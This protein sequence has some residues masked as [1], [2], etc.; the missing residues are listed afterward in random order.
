MQ[1]DHRL[2]I[3]E[4]FFVRVDDFLQDPFDFWYVIGIGDAE[5]KINATLPLSR[6]ILDDPGPDQ[7]VG[8]DN[9]LVVK[10]QEG[11]IYQAHLINLA[12]N[13]AR[14]DRVSDVKRPIEEDHHSGREIRQSIL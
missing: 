7:V 10:S 1:F 4:Y 8:Q 9:R 12:E 5:N 2:G 6:D 3:V 14:L 11:R 13:A